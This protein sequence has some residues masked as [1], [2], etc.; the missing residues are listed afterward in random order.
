MPDSKLPRALVAVSEEKARLTLSAHLRYHG[1]LVE[2]FDGV[3]ADVCDLVRVHCPSLLMLSV[4]KDSHTLARLLHEFPS[5]KVVV[6]AP[7]SAE[8]AF[9]AARLGAQRMLTLPLDE[10]QLSQDIFSIPAADNGAG[11]QT[12]AELASFSS[13]A[14]MQEI[15]ETVGKVATTS[16]TVLIRG[17]SGVGKELVA[18]MIYSQSARRDRPFVKVNCAAIPHELLESELFGY[19]AGAFTGAQQPKPGKFELAD[20]GTLF[21]DEIGEM[22]PALQAKLLHVLQ[23]GQ[24]ARLGAKRDTNVD[25]RLLCATNKPLEQR[26]TE[27]LF[28]EDLFYRINVVTVHVPPLRE[29]RDEIRGLIEHFL[30]RYSKVYE[31]HAPPFTDEVLSFLVNYSWPGNIRE[32]E[33]LVKRYVIVGGATQI[34]RELTLHMLEQAE[35]K[36]G[37]I[38]RQSTSESQPPLA[39]EP[40]LLEIGRRAA[41]DAEQK[42]IRAMLL[43]TKWNRRE[44]ARRLKVSY[45]ALLNKIQLMNKEE[46]GR[47]ALKPRS[48]I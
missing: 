5:L 42:A 29:R 20:G 3:S 31:R 14:R 35:S 27:G 32:L 46:G 11:K 22:H 13:S 39:A 34:V 28:R 41:W 36:T 26:V 38:N 24:F 19:E 7:P 8:T 33:N 43:E 17:E 10:K 48:G 4:E 45:K 30:A 2:R 1:W 15:L 44:A 23:D 6:I 9:E 47:D 25:V 37:G 21:L 16:A 40:T 18:R 12:G